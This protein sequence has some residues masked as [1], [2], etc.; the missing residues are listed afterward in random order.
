MLL[1]LL[2]N[3]T[4]FENI[5]NLFSPYV[6]L[7]VLRVGAGAYWIWFVIVLLFGASVGSFLTM[8][9]YRLPLNRD[10][11][12]PIKSACPMCG[13]ALKTRH[14]I[15]ILSWVF[16]RGRCGY[17][18]YPISFRYPLIELICLALF[19]ITFWSFYWTASLY[20]PAG[21]FVS[22][23]RPEFNS[24]GPLDSW[25]ALAVMMVLVACLFAA[26]IIDMK[27]YIIPLSIP[28]FAAG[29]AVIVLPIGAWYFEDLWMMPMTKA[30][31]GVIAPLV[32]DDWLGPALG[33]ISGLAI[34]YGLLRLNLIPRS[35]DL[36][37]LS[38]EQI[39][40]AEEAQARGDTKAYLE[41]LDGTPEQWM[42]HPGPRIEMFKELLFLAFP[43]AG[44]ILG[45]YYP[46]DPAAFGW[47]SWPI[48]VLVIGGMAMGFL[49]GGIIVW[50]VRIFGTLLFGKEAMGLGDVHLIAC[51]GV[52]LGPN[53][54]LPLLFLIAPFPT[55]AATVI[56]KG[57]SSVARK[58]FHPVPFGPGLVVATLLLI[59]FRQ[60][61]VDYVVAYVAPPA[62]WVPRLTGNLFYL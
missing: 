24:V 29:F 31:P 14:N 54:D 21:G 3:L 44:F 4:W 9:T 23:F 35:F 53:I 62:G 45:W 20:S 36:G 8:V 61:I 10:L 60:P 43:I 50:A 16:L 12:H 57:V 15:P 56:A 58:R 34:A 27:W 25:P 11:L 33:G 51:V 2:A 5:E 7:E 18:R 26:F 40:N 13:G 32:N 52:I 22:G 39:R 59:L 1:T 55:I 37:M 47:E 6:D 46:P 49:L 30:R 17:C 28:Y 41:A 48:A 42:N 19:A 38:D